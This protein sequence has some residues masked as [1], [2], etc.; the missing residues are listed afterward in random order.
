[1]VSA[2]TDPFSPL[3][4]GSC[5]GCVCRASF[6]R[7]KYDLKA[8]GG[9]FPAVVDLAD[10]YCDDRYFSIKRSDIFTTFLVGYSV[11]GEYLSFIKL[12]FIFSVVME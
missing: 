8:E 10:L 7:T 12:T 4:V 5:D 1:M 9:N 11:I 6:G 3:V 2:G